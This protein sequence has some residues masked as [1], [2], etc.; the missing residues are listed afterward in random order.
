[1]TT[2]RIPLVRG[3]A[4]EEF[5]LFAIIESKRVILPLKGI[6]CDFSI[7][8]GIGDVSMTQL[9]RQDNDKP[10]DCEYLFPLPA[11]AS[12][13]SCEADINGR[14][15]RAQVRERQEAR[16]IAA[17]KKAAGF[18]TALVEAERENLFTL[19]LG[20][21]QPGDLVIIQLKYFQTVRSLAGLPSIE[22]PFCPGIRY[23]PGAPL[24]R[25]NTGKGVVDDTDEV[26]DASRITP[27]RIDAEHPDAAYID[28]RGTLDGKFVDEKEVSSPSHPITVHRTGEQLRVSLAHKG[29]VPDRDFVLRWSEKNVE[30][31]ASRAWIREKDKEAY[32]L[33]E[34][35][36]P[37]DAPNERAPVDFY[38]VVDR[39]GSMAGEKWNKAAEALQSCM[40][41][42]GPADRAMVTFFEDRFQDFA[43]RP[44]SAQELLQDSQFQAVKNL[45][46]AGGTQLRPALNH[47][48]D[49]AAK[50]S[51]N[52]FKNLILITDAQIGNESAILELLKTVPN[53]PVHCFGID[54]ALNDSLLLALCRQQ[55]GTFHSLNPNDDIKQA[56]TSLG[57]TLG[58]PVLLD[59]RLSDGWELADAVI[60]NLYAGQIHYL[61]ARSS[62]GKPLELHSRT[63]SSQPARIGFDTQTASFDAPYLHWCRSRIQRFLAEAETSAAVA[64]SIKSNLICPLTAF[65]AWDESERVPIASQQLVQPSSEIFDIELSLEANFCGTYDDAIPQGSRRTT[66]LNRLVRGDSM[67]NR[68]AGAAEAPPPPRT[69]PALDELTLKRELSDICHKAGIADW[70]PIVKTIFDWIAEATGAE[71]S[72]RLDLL[73]RLI[74]EIKVHTAQ[75]DSS[76]NPQTRTQVQETGE[77]IRGLLK[78]FVNHLPLP[79]PS[80]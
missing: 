28:V 72:K 26:P 18:R 55:G 61:S 27:V 25:S 57:K 53:F 58:Q 11:D 21:V 77:Q 15:I 45:G 65:I 29:D 54:V 80:N 20:N 71:R 6:E 4:P 8:S 3:R 39:S 51:G 75:I 60:P 19:S 12:V 22:I 52:Q 30:A 31:V 14:T 73:N 40:K 38:F 44:L 69:A 59:L 48:L 17:E 5:G 42:L 16:Q 23:I 46:T 56:V 37:K 10:M 76:P 79:K 78:T 47:V 62:K 7:V 36:A 68:F 9:F 35:R 32:A 64:L 74:E 1:M 41:V 50:H 13:Y 43:E 2:P 66:L 49:V 67:S 24:I 33:L 34:I 70:Q 63:S